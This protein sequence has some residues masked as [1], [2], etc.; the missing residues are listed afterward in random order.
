MKRCVFLLLIFLMSHSIFGQ[1][2]LADILYSN[3]EYELAAKF[4]SEADSLNSQQ[5]TNHALCYYLNNNFYKAVPLF[6]KAINKDTGNI[7]LKYHYG[8]SLKSIGRNQSAKK[9]LSNLY[10]KDSLNPYLELQLNSI[11]S[12]KKWDTIQFFKKLAVRH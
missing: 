1:V 2:K 9:I 10:N 7:F 8:V 4:Y 12:L 3:F 6:E 11:D 5:M